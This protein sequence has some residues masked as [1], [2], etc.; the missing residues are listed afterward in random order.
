M[1]SWVEEIRLWV[2]RAPD[3]RFLAVISIN[4]STRAG[5][6]LFQYLAG[7]TQ[8]FVGVTSGLSEQAA[9]VR[10]AAGCVLKLRRRRVLF[11]RFLFRKSYVYNCHCFVLNLEISQFAVDFSV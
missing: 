9:L 8:L 4:Y 3:L 11:I 5:E 6:R 1:L 10:G 7:S 2:R